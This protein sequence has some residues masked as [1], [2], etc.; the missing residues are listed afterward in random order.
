MQ[1]IASWGLPVSDRL[2]CVDTL[3]SLI[4]HSRAI[5]AARAELPFDIDGVVSK[6]DRLDWPQRLGFVAK[7]PRWALAHQFPADRPQP[8]LQA[9]ASQLG[10]PGKLT[11]ETG[12]ASR[13]EGVWQHV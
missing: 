8:P 9:I 12:R 7:A 2:T 11:P 13:R 10:R 4:A 6:V 1:A 5:E 3:E